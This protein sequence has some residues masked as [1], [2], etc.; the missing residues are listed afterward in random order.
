[1]IRRIAFLG[2]V[3][4][5]ILLFSGCASE[6]KPPAQ[7]EAPVE[8]PKTT[9]S[10]NNTS[11]SQETP[12][13][14]PKPAPQTNNWNSDGI[15]SQNEYKNSKEFGN[16]RF[17]LY[18]SNDDEYIYMAIKGQTSG[19]V[20]IGFEPTQAMKDADMIFGWVTGGSS[21]ILDIYSTGAFGPHPPDQQL[22]GT[23]DLIETSGSEAGGFTII[24]FKRKLNTGDRYDKAFV[25]GQNINIIWGL[26]SSDNLDSPHTS[27][28]SG[29]IK[30]D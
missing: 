22:G 7:T 5:T 17:T 15:L 1:M 2:I 18:W 27:R 21:T 9:E 10:P 16:G 20:S 25:N 12:V 19:G 26:G 30:L 3:L 13:E 11:V 29:T 24:E 14:E 4:C 23:T 6:N 28:G 8:E